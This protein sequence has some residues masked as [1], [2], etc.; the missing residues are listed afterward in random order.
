MNDQMPDNSVMIE[1]KLFIYFIT[2][3]IV[4]LD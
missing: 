2:N 3:L 4:I 1:K